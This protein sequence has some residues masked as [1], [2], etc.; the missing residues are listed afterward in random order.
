MLNKLRDAWKARG[1]RAQASIEYQRALEGIAGSADPRVPQEVRALAE[2]SGLKP[3]ELANLHGQV[4]RGL[5]SHLLEDG[6]LDAH[7]DKRLEI[8]MA[9]L[10]VSEEASGIPADILER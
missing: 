9:E 10:G 7:E 3:S 6:R 4:V 8:L 5:F 1:D 2:A